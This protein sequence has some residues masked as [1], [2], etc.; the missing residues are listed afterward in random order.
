MGYTYARAESK[1]DESFVF[2]RVGI[3]N[4]QSIKSRFCNLVAGA[5]KDLLR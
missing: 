2:Q 3:L 5:I 4:R 1:H